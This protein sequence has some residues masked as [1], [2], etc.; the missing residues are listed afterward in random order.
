MSLIELEQ[1]VKKL[2]P[3]EFR[4]FTTWLDEYAA[5]QWDQQIEQDVTSGKFT[6]LLE[7]VDSEF[8]AGKCKE[9]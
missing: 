8:S 7:K 3:S 2:S 6:K 9:L 1:E 5:T 4:A